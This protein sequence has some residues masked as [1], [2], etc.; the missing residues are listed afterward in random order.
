MQ[1]NTKILRRCITYPSLVPNTLVV[2]F[3]DYIGMVYYFPSPDSSLT[4]CTQYTLNID[5][6]YVDSE[7][8]IYL[9]QGWYIKPLTIIFPVVRVILLKPTSESNQHS[10]N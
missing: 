3:S 8:D 4:F 6:T 9:Y 10:D 2:L 1:P 7:V 5:M